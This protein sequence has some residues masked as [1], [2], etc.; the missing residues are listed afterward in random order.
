MKRL[1]YY[2]RFDTY[3]EAARVAKEHGIAVT[4]GFAFGYKSGFA[5]YTVNKKIRDWKSK[6]IDY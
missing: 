5:A 6:M 1:T 4:D 3:K 2:K